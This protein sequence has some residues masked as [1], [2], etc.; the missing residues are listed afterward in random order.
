MKLAMLVAASVLATACA[1]NSPEPMGASAGLSGD[2][3]MVKIVGLPASEALA[4]IDKKKLAESGGAILEVTSDNAI[5]VEGA[6]PADVL[7]AIDPTKLVSK[8]KTVAKAD[9]ELPAEVRAIVESGKPYTTRDLA[10]AQLKAVQ[11]QQ[12]G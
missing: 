10:A 5:A 1:T 6:K 8:P 11:R 3:G 7:A 9:G 2:E 12:P 4:A